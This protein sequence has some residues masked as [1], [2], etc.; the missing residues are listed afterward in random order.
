MRSKRTFKPTA[1]DALEDRS[2]PSAMGMGGPGSVAMIDAAKVARDFASFQ[3]TYVQDLNQLFPPPGSTTAAITRSQFDSAVQG[4]LGDLV[5]AIGNDVGNL[6]SATTL[7]ATIAAEIT[8]SASTS[9]QSML[10]G[11][12]T[13]TGTTRPEVR[14]FARQGIRDIGQVADQVVTQVRTSPPPTGTITWQTLQQDLKQVGTAFQTFRT[15]YNADVKLLLPPSGSTTP[16]ITRATFDQD[17]QTAL[18]TL[19]QDVQKALSGLPASLQS[20]LFT[21]I[22]NDLLTGSATT[23]GSLQARLATLPTPSGPN[24]FTSFGFRIWS[25]IDIA[26]AQ[27]RVDNV[28][29]M[30]V[31][32]Y[33]KSL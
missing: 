29:S 3:R 7:T 26:V 33:N 24:F 2:V 12:A 18:Q 32:N 13:P 4:S 10:G 8:G 5:K 1:G 14:A 20:T 23:G 19:N 28:I 6:P 30:A 31:T 22:Q 16:A 15:S 25:Q 27:G 11:I 9:L 17:V 21:T